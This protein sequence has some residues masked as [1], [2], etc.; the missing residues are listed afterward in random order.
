MREV[1]L[2]PKNALK[3]MI[4]TLFKD[5]GEDEIIVRNNGMG[6]GREPSVASS[7]RGSDGME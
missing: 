2:V 3:S 1:E 5:H 4:Q 7:G 6:N